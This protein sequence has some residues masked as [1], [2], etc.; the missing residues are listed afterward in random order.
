MDRKV[1]QASFD[2]NPVTRWVTA[3]D[4]TT[5]QMPVDR[6]LIESNGV[7]VP[8][9]TIDGIPSNPVPQGLPAGDCAT[10]GS[11]PCDTCDMPRIQ[12]R[13]RGW[14][15]G[16]AF[17]FLEPRSNG[18]LAI[19]T[20]ENAAQSSAIRKTSF[21]YD[22]E[23]SPRVWLEWGSAESLGWRVQ[24]WQLDQDAN[25]IIAAAPENG[26]GVVAPVE[27][28]GIDISI[29]APGETLQADN[30][31]RL[32]TI[33]LEGTRRVDFDCWSFVAAG[34]LR[35][36][37]IDQQYRAVSANV[38]GV[39]SGSI[40]QNRSL[41]GIGPTLFIE[42]RRPATCR[43]SVFSNFRASLLF[44]DGDTTLSAGEDLDLA[45]AFTTTSTSQSNS[46]L[47]ILESQLGLEWCTPVTRC[48]D[49]LVNAALEGQWWSGVGTAADSKADLGL[50][51]FAIGLGLQY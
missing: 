50:V 39:T 1:T 19:S 51:G 2:R 46:V 24:W 28:P 31:I 17:T 27:L 18:N 14:D 23:L 33:D 40:E 48:H 36:A 7:E 43:L 21:E 11:A 9:S 30:H 22:M 5:T 41:D 35:F 13:W 49:F 25:Q 29:S 38:N 16:F 44:G 3:Q 4:G 42:A 32:Y 12:P 15:A 8:Y 10:C 34:G 6:T 20:T 45:S 47:P 26:L 37:K